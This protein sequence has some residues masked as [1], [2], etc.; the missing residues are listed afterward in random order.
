M[1]ADIK[2]ENDFL[3]F[4]IWCGTHP[5][6]EPHLLVAA[7]RKGHGREKN[8]L[9]ACLTSL[10]LANSS[11]LLL[12]HFFT[13]IKNY[14]FTIQ[15]TVMLSSSLGFTWDSSTRMG[16]LRY[17][18]SRTEKLP[19]SLPFHRTLSTLHMEYFG[20]QCPF[21]IS[22]WCHVCRCPFYSY[23]QELKPCA[24]FCERKVVLMFFPQ[25]SLLHPG[26]FLYMH[27]TANT[28]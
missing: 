5:S 18:V 25:S 2:P 27:S 26:W 14:F 17:P 28:Q 6:F 20:K 3:D 24:T 10:S 1:Q 11:I 7:H 8:L 9:F 22:I 16:L 13:W 12:R 19:D 4:I 21:E 15:C 23:Y